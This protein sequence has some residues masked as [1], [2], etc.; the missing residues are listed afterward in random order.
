DLGEAAGCGDGLRR[1]LAVR[2]GDRRC[3]ETP[4]AVAARQLGCLAGRIG[5]TAGGGAVT[6]GAAGVAGRIAVGL[7]RDR[8][9]LGPSVDG[10]VSA[11]V[12]RAAAGSGLISGDDA[13]GFA[14]GR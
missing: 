1:R 4:A 12:Q 8:L 13:A 9:Y 14:A 10:G 7:G 11:P 5:D 2:P 3:E 6:L